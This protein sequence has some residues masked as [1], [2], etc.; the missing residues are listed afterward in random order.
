MVA[1]LSVTSDLTRGHPPGEAM[2]AC[3]LATELA[4]RAGLDPVRQS[5]VY[6]GTLLRFV[7]CA[8]T[9]H[10]IAAALGG[11][12][13]AVRA[14][15]DLIDP[16]V[17]GQAQRFLAGL[18]V[19]AG[20]LRALG[21]PAGV[22]RLRAEGARADCEVGAGLARRL[23][24]PDEVGRAILDAFE[25][26]DGH[27]VPGGRAGDG[28]TLAARFAAVGF[29]AIMVSPRGSRGPRRPGGPG[30]WRAAGRGSRQRKI[31]RICDAGGARR[32][33]AAAAR[34]SWGGP[35]GHCRSSLTEGADHGQAQ[36]AGS[37]R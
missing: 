2:R 23:R 35:A 26:Y 24:L 3:L 30:S 18:G 32:K 29:T 6:Y 20:Q 12:D 5:E 14:A 1:S 31:L 17:P 33:K 22:A 10:E 28:I 9:S 11:D 15:G 16:T 25:R 36:L 21:G 19:S 34:R 13:V 37:G 7:G 8:A 27:G 4:R